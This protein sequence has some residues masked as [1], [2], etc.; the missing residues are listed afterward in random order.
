M[1]LGRDMT[2]LRYQSYEAR[3]EDGD[4]KLHVTA[5]SDAADAERW[6]AILVDLSDPPANI[7]RDQR[8]AMRL[9]DL[10]PMAQEMLD[11]YVKCHNKP[12]K[13]L[14]WHKSERTT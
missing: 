11:A 2:N 9:E 3:Y 14:E 7:Q 8:A 12:S 5:F 10:L 4:L 1:S 13:L 6:C